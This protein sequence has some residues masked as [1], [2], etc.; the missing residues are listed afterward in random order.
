[1]PFKGDDAPGGPSGRARPAPPCRRLPSTAS[2]GRKAPRAP[3]R[4]TPPR[5]CSRRWSWCG[6]ARGWACLRAGRGLRENVR[7]AG[8]ADYPRASGTPLGA[9]AGWPA[10]EALLAGASVALVVDA[11]EEEA[12]EVV[13]LPAPLA[14]RVL[15]RWTRS[16]TRCSPLRCRS[17]SSRCSTW[18]RRHPPHWMCWVEET[19]ALM[20]ALPPNGRE[21]VL[22]MLR[23]AAATSAVPVPVEKVA[24]RRRPRRR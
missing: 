21:M 14:R 3:S 15:L 13:G 22:G 1:M 10:T 11:V 16:T 17:S 2:A 7:V 20:R 23:G 5:R 19:I 18:S 6:N 12:G 4:S 9:S 24:A 8:R